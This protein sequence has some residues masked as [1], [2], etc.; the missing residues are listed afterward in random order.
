MAELRFGF[1]GAVVDRATVLRAEILQDRDEDPETPLDANVKVA[2]HLKLSPEGQ[3]SLVDLGDVAEAKF[4]SFVASL[5]A[6]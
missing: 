1:T 4:Q 5:K 2:L 3:Q 6:P